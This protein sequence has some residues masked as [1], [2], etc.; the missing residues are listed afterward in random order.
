MLLCEQIGVHTKPLRLN[1]TK[2]PV[3]IVPL[4][5]WYTQPEE[6]PADTLYV[7]REIEDKDLTKMAWMDNKLCVWN[8]VKE[9]P[10]KYFA[11]L[12]DERVCLRYD[13]PVISFSHFVPR[14]DLIPASL[15]DLE[16]VCNERQ[17]MDLPDL[18][19]PNTQGANVKF[20]F[21]RYAG[22]KTID[23][24]I[25]QLKSTIHIFGHQHRNRDCVIDS[26]RYV[27]YCLG[28]PRERAMGLMWGM[29]EHHGPRQIWPL[30]S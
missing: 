16:R 14:Y 5:S 2:H 24:Q 9:F 6:D 27:S 3:T 12:N 26:V 18:D 4:F 21:S 7:H 1:D 19:K 30:A 22:C 15:Q 28:Y 17:R 20:N 23:V 13:C 8:S 29:S 10:A 11:R 25:R